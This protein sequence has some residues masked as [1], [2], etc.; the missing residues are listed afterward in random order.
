M[1]IRVLGYALAIAAI[2]TGLVVDSAADSLFAAGVMFLSGACFFLADYGDSVEAKW[3]KARF[4]IRNDKARERAE[5][6]LNKAN[7]SRLPR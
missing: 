5:E 7:D 1:L 3:K 4:Q 2:A 6:Q